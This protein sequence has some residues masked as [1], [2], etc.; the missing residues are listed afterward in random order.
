MNIKIL[1]LIVRV[2]YIC[3]YY[4]MRTTKGEKMLEGLV[5]NYVI[6]NKKGL[7]YKGTAHHDDSKNWTSKSQ[8]FF[9]YTSHGAH[10]KVSRHSFYFKN[11]HVERLL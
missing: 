10:T 11:C 4:F 8:E 9:K 1:D 7:V 6:K 2:Y 5:F 3:Y